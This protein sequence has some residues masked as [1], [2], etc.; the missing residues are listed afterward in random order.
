MFFMVFLRSPQRETPKN[1][2]IKNDKNSV[3]DVCRFFCKSFS[4]QF[5][6]KTLFVVLL[7]S[8]RCET[9][10]NAIKPHKNRGKVDIEIFVDFFGESFRHGLFAKIFVVVF[11]NSPCRETPQAPKRTKKKS[12]GGSGWVWDVDKGPAKKNR[13]PPWWVGGWEYE[14]GLGSDF[15]WW[16][17]FIVFLNSSHRETPKN[18]IKKIEKKSVL[19]FWSN[20]LLKLFDTIFFVK[21]FL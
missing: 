14:K 11:L 7:N 1:V 12:T 21:R 2:I 9:P 15:F 3:L 8:N 16:F 10:E 5:F 6:C 19:D 17:F 20:F 18:V 4:S 13:G